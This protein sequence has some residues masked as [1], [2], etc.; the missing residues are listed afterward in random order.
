MVTGADRRE[1]GPRSTGEAEV[2]QRGRLSWRFVDVPREISE[3]RAH[4]SGKGFLAEAE[5]VVVPM[6]TSVTEKNDKRVPQPN[7]ASD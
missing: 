4:S 3:I 1:Q 6:S 7:N 2:F 5:E